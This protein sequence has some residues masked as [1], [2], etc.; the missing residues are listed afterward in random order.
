MTDRIATPS[1]RSAARRA[2][3][4]HLGDAVNLETVIRELGAGSLS[5]AF[6]ATA[7]RCGA[8]RA[9]TI[10]GADVSHG[11]L[12]D[13]SARVGGWLRQSSIGRGD[14]VLLSGRNSVDFVTAYLAVLRVGATVVLASPALTEPEL[15]HLV[16]DSR[17]RLAFASDD[18]LP[19]LRSLAGACG[20]LSTVVAMGPGAD[21][22]SL[23]E[24]GAA[25]GPALPAPVA[26]SDD[27]AV[28]AYTS[29]TT[30]RPKAVPLTHQNLL[31]S[32]RAAMLAWRWRTDDV[33]VHCLPLCHQHGLG[34]VHATLI[35]GSRAVIESR[36]DAARLSGAL[37]SE[38]ATVLFAVPAIYER[39]VASRECVGAGLPALRLAICGSAPLSPA[40]AERVAA[41]FGIPPLQRYGTTESGLDVSEL[42]DGPQ[43][44]DSVGVPLPG[45]ELAVVDA[46]GRPVAE[47][48]TGEIVV[49]GPQV[50]GGYEQAAEWGEHCFYPGGWFRTGDLGHLEQGCLVISG[51]SKELVITGGLNVYPREVELALEE[52][53]SV[54]RAAVVGVPS[55]EWGDEVVAFVVR[56]EGCSVEPAATLASLR[57][58][59]APY[60]V[61]KRLFVLD[62][63]PV[64]AVGKLNRSRLAE[65]AVAPK[66]AA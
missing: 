50:F 23:E 32:I 44:P 36:F 33:L 4:L 31:A 8:A 14:R 55:E 10:D 25:P 59:L 64:N 3:R 47:G 24:V 57:S 13:H 52:D 37:R 56:A 61:P 30:G 39:L 9:L 51:R 41:V 54:A 43:V 58:R 26:G 34:G 2:W 20:D 15:A 6:R 27:V 49:R 42:Y 48:D 18:A 16:R 5:G 40:L 7:Q 45:V 12:E 21:V 60:K 35:A 1:V 28:L 53:P 17:A 46:H 11:Q 38:A 65:L 19:R 63:L 66:D 29:G 22:P 62:A